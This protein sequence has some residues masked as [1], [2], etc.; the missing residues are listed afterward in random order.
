MRPAAAV[1]WLVLLSACSSHP[2]PGVIP[3]DLSVPDLSLPVDAA[4]PLDLT[5]DGSGDMATSPCLTGG[6]VI[7]LDGE[8]GNS[9][10]MGTLT[11]HPGGWTIAGGTEADTFSYTTQ[12]G[13]F[14]YFFVFSSVQLGAPLAVGRYDNATRHATEAPGVPGMDIAIHSAGCN[15]LTGSFEIQSIAG[16]PNNGSFTELTATFEQRCGIDTASLRGC[17]HFEN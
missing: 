2:P 4:P 14:D 6:N 10:Y 9:V 5:A 16:G 13:Q 8:P 12:V 17:I 11:V 3:D 7:Y 15:T 1:S